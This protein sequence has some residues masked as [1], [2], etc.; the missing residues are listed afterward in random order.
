MK[1]LFLLDYKDIEDNDE[2]LEINNSVY[3]IFKRYI[4]G[5]ADYE[6]NEL[7]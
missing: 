5:I 3:Q 2:L 6:N 1:K 7:T 4:L